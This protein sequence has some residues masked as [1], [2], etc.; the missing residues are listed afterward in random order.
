MMNDQLLRT[1]IA[2]VT[3]DSKVRS[4]YDERENLLNLQKNL[5]EQKNVLL[6]HLEELKL[7]IN[8][9]QKNVNAQELSMKTLDHREAELKHRLDNVTGVKEYSSLKNEVNALHDQQ[10]SCEQSLIE[11]WDKLDYIQKK[12]KSELSLS[13]AKNFELDEQQ[14]DIAKKIQDLDHSIDEHEQQRKVYVEVVP[15]ELLDN[16]EH[17][18]GQVKNPVVP[19][20]NN[21][22]SACFYLVPGQDLALLKKGKF[23]PCKSCYRILYCADS[24][25]E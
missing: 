3:F 10:Q 23:I 25:S 15:V 5:A 8:E 17:M 13:D 18:R 16:Y 9:Y 12:Y 4:L 21:S 22:C 7:L 2:L 19:V 20:E 6:Q 14:R 1:F 24:D 11:A